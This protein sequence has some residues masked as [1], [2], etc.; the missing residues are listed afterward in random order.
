MAVLILHYQLQMLSWSENTTLRL[1]RRKK[2]N[3]GSAKRN[4]RES[5]KSVSV[6]KT[7]SAKG[8][9]P[10]GMMSYKESGWERI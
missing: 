6:L 2:Q 8:A 7:K 3:D 5:G 9:V 4:V 10:L 1:V